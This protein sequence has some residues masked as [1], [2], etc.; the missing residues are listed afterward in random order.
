[1]LFSNPKRTVRNNVFWAESGRNSKC[2]F[3]KNVIFQCFHQLS[4]DFGPTKNGISSGFCVL[5]VLFIHGVPWCI[6]RCQYLGRNTAFLLI[7]ARNVPKS[8]F[9]PLFYVFLVLVKDR[10]FRPNPNMNAISEVAPLKSSISLNMSVWAKSNFW[11]RGHG[12]FWIRTMRH[13]K[14][15][16]LK[17][18]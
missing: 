4:S 6:L 14:H 10:W 7:Y 16:I 17:Q 15:F 18:T 5:E 3:L 2:Q 11:I 1:M 9:L 8:R 12:A 13:P